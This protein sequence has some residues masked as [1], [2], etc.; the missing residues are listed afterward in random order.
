MEAGQSK[1][2]R[3]EDKRRPIKTNTQGCQSGGAARGRGE[4]REAG[5]AVTSF[6]T[7]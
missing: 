4:Q 1:P 2:Q 7:S 3:T 6:P 5:R